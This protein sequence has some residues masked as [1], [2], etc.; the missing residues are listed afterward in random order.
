MSGL[1][2]EEKKKNYEVS[3]LL[4]KYEMESQFYK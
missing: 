4:K 1:Y 2:Q 3:N